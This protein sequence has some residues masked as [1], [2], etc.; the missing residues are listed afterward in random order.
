MTRAYLGFGE[1]L[2]Q[3]RDRRGLSQLELAVAAGCDPSLISCY[4]KG[5]KG[6]SVKTLV[7]LADVLEFDTD[8]LL[9]RT[10]SPQHRE[11]DKSTFSEIAGLKSSQVDLLR[12]LIRAMAEQN[13]P[14]KR[15]DKFPGVEAA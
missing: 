6:P 14:S 13:R 2:K 1:R 11:G 12:T 8:F 9:G 10:V 5:H 15:V 3:A 7:L 4:E